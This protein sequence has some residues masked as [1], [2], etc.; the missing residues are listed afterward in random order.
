[1]VLLVGIDLAWTDHRES[2]F[3]VVEGD[4]RGWRL[5]ALD[6][7]VLTIAELSDRCAGPNVVAAIDAPLVV[8]PERY[9]ERLVGRA[10]GRYK[11]SAHSASAAVRARRD[12]GVRLCSELVSLGWSGDPLAKEAP[13]RWALEVY[14][15]TC[16]VS[17]F[18]LSERIKYKTKWGLAIA[19]IGLRELQCRLECS[20]AAELPS[21]A[22]DARL[23]TVLRA[24]VTE[25]RGQKLKHLEDQLDALTCVL[26]AF[27][28]W[29]DGVAPCEVFGDGAQGYI[30]VPGLRRDSRSDLHA[31]GCVHPHQTKDAR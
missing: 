6:A 8:G 29:R 2:G 13:Q 7:E 11:A 16:H 19:R 15:H 20:F 22:L 24:D 5:V 17:W 1:M 28:A 31:V 3:A 4:A 21:L 18:N 25:L 9:A 26:A 10:F 14:P 30:A 12:A 27:Y 23:T